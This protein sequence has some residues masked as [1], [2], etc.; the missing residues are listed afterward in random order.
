MSEGK[1]SVSYSFLNQYQRFSTEE[2]T[3][4]T[5]KW[6]QLQTDFLSEKSDWEENSKK[7]LSIHLSKKFRILD[8]L[9]IENMQDKIYN[10]EVT[11]EY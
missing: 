9:V 8:R 1:S 7:P 6:K 11:W 5:E 4:F 3:I 10:S 2:K